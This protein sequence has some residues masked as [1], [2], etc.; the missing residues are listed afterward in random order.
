MMLFNW[1]KEIDRGRERKRNIHSI[2]W[3]YCNNCEM[4]CSECGAR[5]SVFMCET[6]ADTR[7]A[8]H[9]K[10]EKE[11]NAI[12]KT[13]YFYLVGVSIVRILKATYNHSRWGIVYWRCW[14]CCC[15]WGCSRCCCCGCCNHRVTHAKDNNRKFA[16]FLLFCTHIHGS[17]AAALQAIPNGSDGFWFGLV[18]RAVTGRPTY[19]PKNWIEFPN[20]S[21][22]HFCFRFYF[23]IH[24]FTAL[25]LYFNFF[26][27]LYLLG[28]VLIAY[29]PLLSAS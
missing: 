11:K 15:C 6:P 20:V 8:F 9:L 12:R 2:L 23:F 16:N 5:S 10:R 26:F 27:S 24:S 18:W 19:S 1:C 3:L 13:W 21:A 17:R 4:M 22:I 29:L 7:L 25:E 14:C 28:C